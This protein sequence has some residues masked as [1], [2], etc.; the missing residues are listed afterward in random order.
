VFEDVSLVNYAAAKVLAA[1]LGRKDKVREVKMAREKSSFF[2]AQYER[3][4][5]LARRGQ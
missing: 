4:Y 3:A 1:D 5:D 2:R